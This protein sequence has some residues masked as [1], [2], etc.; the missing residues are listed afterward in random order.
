[1]EIVEAIVAFIQ[2]C[3]CFLEMA[4]VSSSGA[5]GYTGYQV[6]R[7]RQKA[8]RTPVEGEP[9]PAPPPSVWR[10]VAWLLIGVALI[11][12][13]CLKWIAAYSPLT[14]GILRSP[15]HALFFLR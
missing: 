10:F 12:L 2:L 13:V 6:Y 1:M 14:C 11:V 4:A 5:A 8:K 9:P 15:S 3:G 7:G